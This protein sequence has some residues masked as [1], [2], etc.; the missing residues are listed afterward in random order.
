LDGIKIDLKSFNDKFYKDICKG[1]L[2]PVLDTL[3]LIKNKNKWLEIVYLMI[4]TLNDKKEEIEKMCKWILKNL[5]PDVPVHFTRFHPIY[6]LRNLPPT[7]V[8]SLEAA[9]EIGMKL[10]LNYVYIG[11]VPGHKGE[12]TYCPKCNKILLRRIGFN[13]LFNHIK[14]GTCPYCHK[15]IAGIWS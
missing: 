11:N 4:P 14:N 5:G 9:R 6:R 1:E 2:Q 15:K 12:N 13:I 7:P 10:G 3:I 8:S